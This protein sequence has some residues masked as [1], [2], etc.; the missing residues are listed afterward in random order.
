M[1]PARRPIRI[2]FLLFPGVTAL[3]LVGPMDAFTAAVTADGER[4]RPCYETVVIGIDPQELSAESGL[5]L[6]P[7]CMLSSAPPLDTVIIPGGRGLREP[8]VN[9]AITS[10][11]LKSWRGIRR[12]ASVCTG[13]YG[14]APTGLIDGRRVTTHW[15]F[16]ADVALQ[17]PNL[18]VEPDALYL[19]DGR[20]YT[21]AGI[22]AGID[23]ALAMIEADCGASVSLAVARELVVYLRRS[24]GQEQ[25]SQP[26]RFQADS[27]DKF[28]DLVAWIDANLHR[29]LRIDD[30][31]RRVHVGPRHFNRQFKDALGVTPA[32]FVE[33]RRLDE[34]RNRLT[35][36][37]TSIKAISVSVGFGS[38]DAFRRAFE[39]RFG[40]AP[41][42]YRQR[43]G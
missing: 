13:I 17:F 37:R 33:R 25:Y 20:F 36:S 41:G 30:M 5:K 7:H 22:T 12:V 43:F 9:A 15:A 3:D 35:D 18:R 28:G 29:R 34:A 10:W 39:R 42:Q 23:M 2:G 11:L 32:S 16:A 24:G 31:A 27:A 40:V 1:S 38:A 26:L 6:L 21:S 4:S 8:D 14:L 19:R